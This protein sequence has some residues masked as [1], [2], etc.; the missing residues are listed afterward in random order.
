MTTQQINGLKADVLGVLKDRVE[1]IFIDFQNAMQIQSGDI[2]PLDALELE[3]R[4]S[5]LATM[6][7]DILVYQKEGD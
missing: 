7:A 2:S 4:E 1:D 3:K 5:S 6:I